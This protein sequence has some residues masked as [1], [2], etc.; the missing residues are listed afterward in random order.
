MSADRRSTTTAG[1]VLTV[2]FTCEWCGERV[3]IANGAAGPELTDA[4]AFLAQH[5]DC[6]RQ[7]EANPL[8]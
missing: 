3:E 5:R 1:S 8:S 4:Q 7:R 2:V 6:L